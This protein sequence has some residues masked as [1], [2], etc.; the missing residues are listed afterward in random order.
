MIHVFVYE[1]DKMSSYLIN[2]LYLIIIFFPKPDKPYKSKQY[3][4]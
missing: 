4:W 3:K 2:M 1:I